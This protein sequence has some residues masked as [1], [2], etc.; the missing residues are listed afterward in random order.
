[1]KGRPLRPDPRRR[2]WF[3]A[4]VS[5][6]VSPVPPVTVLLPPASEIVLALPV[7][8]TVSLRRPR[9]TAFDEPPSA[10]VS[11]PLPRITVLPPFALTA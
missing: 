10:T 7:M 6:I 4:A 5:R 9:N 8:V 3:A 2:N 11:F 1:M